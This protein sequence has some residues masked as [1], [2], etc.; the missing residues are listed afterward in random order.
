MRFS[1]DIGHMGRMLS[2]SEF[3]TLSKTGNY[4]LAE[5]NSHWFW[6][7]TNLNQNSIPAET[8]ALVISDPNELANLTEFESLSMHLRKDPDLTGIL[9]LFQEHPII[10]TMLENSGGNEGIRISVPRG[11]FLLEMKTLAQ[12]LVELTIKTDGKHAAKS[13]DCF[14]HLGGRR[15]LQGYAVTLFYGLKLHEQVNIGEGTLIAPYEVAN[16]VYELPRRLTEMLERSSLPNEGESITVLVREFKWGT[17]APSSPRA[18]HNLDLDWNIDY[19][20]LGDSEI[21][22]DILS[23]A[24]RGP[25]AARAY[26]FGVDRWLE[27]IDRNFAFGRIGGGGHPYDGW[28]TEKQLSDEDEAVFHDM[29]RG[30]QEYQGKRNVLNR[31][32]RRLA[33]SYNRP[34][35]QGAE[36]SILDYATTLEILYDPGSTEVTYRL[37]T[38]AAY[39]VGSNAKERKEIFDNV[40]AF[41]G[42]RSSLVHGREVGNDKFWKAVENGRDLARR[43]LLKLLSAKRPPDWDNLVLTGTGM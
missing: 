5:T 43:T 8:R 25:L 15:E 30:W 23:V 12:N 36:D 14:L 9:S 2:Y 32:I 16:Q 11:D 20:F 24:I 37:A 18:G 34:G 28:W 21:V 29:I 22:L 17:G 10:H 39:F 41:Y 13:L 1:G 38:R 26:Y 3:L 40:R 7:F 27:E 31:A 35:M 42:V 33:T 4:Q 19:R 6:S